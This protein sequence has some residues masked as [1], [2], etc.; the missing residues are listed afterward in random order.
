LEIEDLS[1]KNGTAHLGGF[2]DELRV[3]HLIVNVADRF[4]IG[5]VWLLALDEQ[6]AALGED[7]AAL[8]A[9]SHD[10]ID[11]ALRAA[12]RGDGITL[13][14][15]SVD[16]VA[17]TVGVLHT[18]SRRRDF[19]LTFLDKRAVVDADP[20]QLCAA[21]GFGTVVLDLT[22]PYTL[23]GQFATNLLSGR[24]H[25]WPLV[26]ARTW[27]DVWRA[28]AERDLSPTDYNSLAYGIDQS[29]ARLGEEL[30]PDTNN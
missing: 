11:R 27:E 8:D 24:F 29:A 16:A 5:S 3:R 13:Y 4:R 22:N 23:P 25:V 20:Y 12:V 19:P 28:F 21:L 9:G 15:E 2:D 17:S 14:A 10:E 18:R 1:S 7:L 30:P 26:V 6:T